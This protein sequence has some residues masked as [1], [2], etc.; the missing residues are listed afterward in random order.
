[1][2]PF[3]HLVSSV[4]GCEL[5]F[6]FQSRSQ[7]VLLSIVFWGLFGFL[8]D[9]SRLGERCER[10][11][12][13]EEQASFPYFDPNPEEGLGHIYPYCTVHASY[14]YNAVY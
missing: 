14:M 3:D 11:L 10:I 8:F 5:G 9:V 13:V 12:T 7:G 4:A 2:V 6:K 1:M